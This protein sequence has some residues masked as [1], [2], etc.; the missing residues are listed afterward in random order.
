MVVPYYG[1]YDRGSSKMTGSGYRQE[2]E[3][4]CPHSES[5]RAPGWQSPKY[6]E[7]LYE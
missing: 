4:K 2:S 3:Q 7:S 1:N 5:G 6:S